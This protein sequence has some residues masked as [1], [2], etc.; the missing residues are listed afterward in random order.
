MKVRA[1]STFVLGVWDVPLCVRSP[2]IA[3][4]CTSVWKCDITKN[5]IFVLWCPPLR[6]LPQCCRFSYF[7]VEVRKYQVLVFSY[8]TF[9]PEYESQQNPGGVLLRKGGQPHERCW[10][11][12]FGMKVR[13]FSISYLSTKVYNIGGAYA[14]ADIPDTKVRSFSIFVHTKVR[15]F[16]STKLR[17]S[18]ILG[19]HAQRRTPQ[20]PTYE[21]IQIRHTYY[22]WV[23]FPTLE[24]PDT[25]HFI[26]VRLMA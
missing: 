12:Y 13:R 7:G 14:K 17:K 15:K 20:T 16:Q 23:R 11:S 19:E 9:I 8:C 5:R 2:N 10:F 18:A 26:G 21:T 1:S 24:V 3:D 22:S 25:Y 4:F 6:T